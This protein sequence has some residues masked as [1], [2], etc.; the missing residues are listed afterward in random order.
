MTKIF[1]VIDQADIVPYYYNITGQKMRVL[2]S[3]FYIKGQMYKLAIEYKDMI[4]ELYLD[5]G[6]FSAKKGKIGRAHV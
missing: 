1:C 3:Y 5:C 2:I 6:A 4:E